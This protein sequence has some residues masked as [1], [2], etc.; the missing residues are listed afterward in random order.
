MFQNQKAKIKKKTA[1]KKFKVE[2]YEK[3]LTERNLLIGISGLTLI[4]IFGFYLTNRSYQR[5]LG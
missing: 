3:Y 5:C 4:V 1:M 2:S